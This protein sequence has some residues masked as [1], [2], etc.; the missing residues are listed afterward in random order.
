[1]LQ[2]ETK[3][4]EKICYIES[5][6]K[7]SLHDLIRGDGRQLYHTSGVYVS[8]LLIVN[9]A[10]TRTLW[11]SIIPWICTILSWSQDPNLQ[12][13]YLVPSNRPWL[14][15]LFCSWHHKSNDNVKHN[16]VMTIS[17][18]CRFFTVQMYTLVHPQPLKEVYMK[19]HILLPTSTPI[20][21]GIDSWQNNYV[22]K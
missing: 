12:D 10:S 19:L 8:V 9:E 1:M 17:F 4:I 21:K 3:W 22:T 15:C 16:I 20:C 7:L 18:P 6:A 14:F 5:Y 2:N 11:C 13:L